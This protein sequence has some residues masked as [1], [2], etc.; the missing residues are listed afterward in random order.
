MTSAPWILIIL[1]IFWPLHLYKSEVT[2][3]CRLEKMQLFSGDTRGFNRGL[4]FKRFWGFFP[5]FNGILM[6]FWGFNYSKMAKTWFLIDPNTFWMIL[7]TSKISKFLGP[8][9][10]PRTFYLSWIYLEKYKENMETSLENMDF[11]NL[12]IWKSQKFRHLGNL[13]LPFFEFWNFEFLFF[14]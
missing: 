14:W 1:R 3:I 13:S 12:R 4:K 10:D 9:V 5:F 6:P 7:G 8:V 2:W 11:W